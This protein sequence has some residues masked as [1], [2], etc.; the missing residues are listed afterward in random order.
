MAADVELTNILDV[1]RSYRSPFLERRVDRWLELSDIS[2]CGT[3]WVDCVTE[4]FWLIV[5]TEGNADETDIHEFE[6]R[7]RDGGRGHPAQDAQAVFGRRED[8][9]CALGPAR[10]GSI[11]ELCRREGIAESLYYSWS[12][13]FLEAGKKRLTGDTARQASSGEVKD[14]RREMHDLKEAL[15]EQV[16]ENRLPKKNALSGV[17]REQAT[18]S[19]AMPN[20]DGA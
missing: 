13:E 15:A 3:D 7:R 20:G 11:A 2:A 4:D 12:K 1:I 16:L 6:R 8:P 5:V 10:R 18:G 14:L 19:S 9:D 17:R